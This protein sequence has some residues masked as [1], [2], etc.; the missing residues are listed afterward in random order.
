MVRRSIYSISIQIRGVPK[1]GY[2][3]I[4]VGGLVIYYVVKIVNDFRSGNASW[5]STS[6]IQRKTR[7]EMNRYH[8]IQ[9]LKY[10]RRE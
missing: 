8:E 4:L 5:R 3:L 6:S 9:K 10:E 2:M 1:M 7:N